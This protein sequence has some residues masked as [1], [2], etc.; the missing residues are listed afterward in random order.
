MAKKSDILWASLM[1]TKKEVFGKDKRLRMRI[2]TPKKVF[3]ACEMVIRRHAV[4]REGI[5]NDKTMEY[6]FVTLEMALIKELFYPEC[7]KRYI[8]T[9]ESEEESHEL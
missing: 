7:P 6:Y 9:E 4:L 2:L 1:T 8:D 5:E 3:K